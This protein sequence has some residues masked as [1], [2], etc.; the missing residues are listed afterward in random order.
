MTDLSKNSVLQIFL[1]FAQNFLEIIF[2]A[3][4]LMQF[5]NL[6]EN[7][8]RTAQAAELV[9]GQTNPNADSH[10]QSKTTENRPT[11]IW[12]ITGTSSGFGLEVTK[13]VL[14]R[15]DS[16]AAT[17]LEPETH[18]ELKKKYND[19]ILPLRLDVTKRDEVD[20]A[21][22]AAVKFFGRIDVVL[23][24]AGIG[25]W[26]AV[27]E[28]SEAELW[29]QMDVNFFGSFRVIQAVLPVLQKQRCGHIIQI[30][31][32]A[33]HTAF[34]LGG[35]YSCSKW[36]VEALNETVAIETEKFGINV[37]IIEPGPFKTNFFKSIKYAENVMEKYSPNFDPAKLNQIDN[38]KI[39]SKERI[40]ELELLG[41]RIMDG[42]NYEEPA[43]VACEIL[44][45]ADEKKPPLRVIVGKGAREFVEKTYKKRLEEW[46]NWK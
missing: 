34:R 11:K 17:A 38:K 45:V 29:K 13:A 7:N 8:L 3:I 9:V 26:G 22:N 41:I 25:Y 24:N 31:S 32:I 28:L 42:S 2:V 21:V 4:I 10:E 14:A 39:T 16:V 43:N 30:S 33:G 23:N 6:P 37:S 20:A 15:G 1:R 27:E 19:K 46:K 5:Q 12:F 18:S 44:K 36:A 40:A 35:A